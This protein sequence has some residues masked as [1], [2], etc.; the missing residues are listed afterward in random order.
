MLKLISSFFING[1][2]LLIFSE[3]VFQ[4][5]SQQ[6]VFPLKIINS[7]YSKYSSVKNVFIKAKSLEQINCF[8]SFSKKFLVDNQQM[9]SIKIDILNSL[10]FGAE[11]EIGSNSQKFNVILDTG[12][13]ILW[14][15][16]IE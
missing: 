13:Q 5:N 16:E 11:I 1:L 14:V 8:N 6:I 7:S 15:P 2:L 10:L 9:L 4:I 3:L 12:S